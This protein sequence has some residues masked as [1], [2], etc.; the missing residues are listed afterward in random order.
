VFIDRGLLIINSA[1][2]ALVGL[3]EDIKEAQ[4]ICLR[5]ALLDDANTPGFEWFWIAI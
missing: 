2:M 1:T 3:N 5:N 4:D